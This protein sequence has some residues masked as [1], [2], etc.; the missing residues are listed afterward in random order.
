MA[1]EKYA[2]YKVFK[3]KTTGEIR[4]V[5]VEDKT[6]LEKTASTTN[7]IELDV[8]PQPNAE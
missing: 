2:T 1:M 3:H 5:P 8:D 4:R 6:E 7:W